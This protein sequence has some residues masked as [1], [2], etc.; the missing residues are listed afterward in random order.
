M[1]EVP[2]FFTKNDFYDTLLPGYL[3][4]A[5][6]IF[7]FQSDLLK[8]TA[9]LDLLTA[10]IFVVL[11][12]AVGL[13]LTQSHR[14]LLFNVWGRRS[15]TRREQLK[16][17]AKQ[18]YFMHLAATKEENDYLDSQ[19]SEY[20]FDVSAAIGLGVVVVANI[21]SSR[22]VDYVS[23]G[24]LAVCVVLLIGAHYAYNDY[25]EVVH[26]LIVQ[27]PLQTPASPPPSPTLS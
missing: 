7:F 5:A 13:V 21:V 2:S 11:G 16:A 24:V 4:V 1:S 20:D 12:P 18:Y 15:K 6:Y 19:E 8:S 26:D 3:A 10:A 22:L 9:S 17:F 25:V 27:H 14:I 23:L